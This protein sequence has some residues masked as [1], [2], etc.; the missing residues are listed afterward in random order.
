MKK[1][2]IIL[3]LVIVYF[4]ILSAQDPARFKKE[5]DS[6]KQLVVE[7][8]P[9]TKLILF[10]GSSSIRMWNN[11]QEYFLN[12]VIIN[13]GFGG[14]H[15]SDLLFYLN[16]IVIKY[17]PDQIF[18]YE[19]DNDVADGKKPVGIMK[20]TKMVVHQLNKVLPSVPIVLISSKPSL[21]R[22]EL[23]Q[24]YTKLND[25]FERQKGCGYSNI[26]SGCG[27]IFHHP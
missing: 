5:I 13:T 6:L 15:M 12:K 21:A 7:R 8:K 18:I 20:D 9:D 1:I 2:G 3:I 22:W 25:R 10:T 19:G 11:I 26:N 4:Q 14:S 27:S 24:T 16:D 17:Q 23:R